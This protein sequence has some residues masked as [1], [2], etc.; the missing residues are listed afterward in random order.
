MHPGGK[1]PLV[2]INSVLGVVTCVGKLSLVLE[3]AEEAVD[4]GTMECIKDRSIGILAL[5]IE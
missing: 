5:R 4:T 2:N 3:Y 1:F